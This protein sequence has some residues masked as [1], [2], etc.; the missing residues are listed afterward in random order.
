[1][2]I[3]VSFTKVV[4]ADSVDDA[5][6]KV[7]GCLDALTDGLSWVETP[8]GEVLHDKTTYK[9]GNTEFTEMN[10]F[11]FEGLGGHSGYGEGSIEDWTDTD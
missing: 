1:M 3:K 8:D 5:Y 7:L 2:K 9:R 4:E 11:V 6:T 10:G